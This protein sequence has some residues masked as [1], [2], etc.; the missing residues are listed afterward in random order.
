MK[1]PS[2]RFDVV[3]ENEYSMMELA[4]LLGMDVPET[5]LLSINQIA[6]IPDGIGK[7]GDAFK[8]A[9]AFVIKRF[10]R[11]GDQAVHIE[12][13]AQVFGVYP[14]DKYG[15]YRNIAQVIGIEGQDETSQNLHADWCS[16]R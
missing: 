10:D 13:F 16:I 7:F 15:E 2:S 12:D 1:L 11:A 6:N 9:Q 14:Q 4:R 3:P 5:Q 8:N